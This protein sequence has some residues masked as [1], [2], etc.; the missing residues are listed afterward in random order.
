MQAISDLF[1]FS[2][3]TYHRCESDLGDGRQGGAPVRWVSDSLD[4][5]VAL[6]PVDG[7]RDARRV[8][9]EAL[10]YLSKGQGAMPGHIE[11]RQRL[12]SGKRQ[13]EGRQGFVNPGQ[14]DL[15]RPGNRGGGRHRRGF[16]PPCLVPISLSFCNQI[17]IALPQ[18][19]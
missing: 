4:K 12:K 13:C 9:L 14:H 16:T 3:G 15:L 17:D 11:Q 10:A 8:Y 19:V 6:E 2:L 7:V 18:G 1:Q 5:A